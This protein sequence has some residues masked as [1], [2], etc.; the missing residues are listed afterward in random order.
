MSN[1]RNI[2]NLPNGDD[3]PIYACRAWVNFNGGTV[4]NPASTTGIYAHGNVS[5]ILDHGSG[6]LT[7]NFETP[8]PDANYAVVVTGE[9]TSVGQGNAA[10]GSQ[11]RADGRAAGSVRVQNW[12]WAG[13]AQD[14]E[15]SV[16]IIH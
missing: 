16:V 3:A 2:A 10:R 15:M 7:I 12:G 9:D 11:V 1:A 13:S 5:T 8:M 6:D 14:V 4:T